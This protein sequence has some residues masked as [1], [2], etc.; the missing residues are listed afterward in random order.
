[1]VVVTE[2]EIDAMTVSQL[3]GNKWPV[4]SI[5]SGAQSAKK[6]IANNIEWLSAFEEVVLMFDMDEPGTRSRRVRAAVPPGKCKVASLPLKDANEM[7][8]GGRGPEVIRP[9]GARKSTGLTA[10]SPS[11]ELRD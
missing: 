4:V 2:G 5:P 8:D 9:S 11:T 3:Q 1:M 10:S 6:A 7:L